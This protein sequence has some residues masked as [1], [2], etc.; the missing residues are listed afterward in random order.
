M[1]A[2]PPVPSPTPS[3]ALSISHAPTHPR[4]HSHTPLLAL[5]PKQGA[6]QEQQ[7]GGAGP[8]PLRHLP[9]AWNPSGQAASC[10]V[11]W[12]LASVPLPLFFSCC[13]PASHR[14]P[15]ALSAARRAWPPVSLQV[16]GALVVPL[17]AFGMPLLGL[18]RSKAKVGPACLPTCLRVFLFAELAPA[19]RGQGSR[20]WCVGQAIME[21]AYRRCCAHCP[22]APRIPL[23]LPP[24]PQPAGSS[25]SSGG[26][27]MSTKKKK[28]K[29]GNVCVCIPCQ[30]VCVECKPCGVSQR[31]ATFPLPMHSFLLPA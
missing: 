13:A 15:C 11:W 30:R 8:P 1:P 2:L 9:G 12:P 18:R 5:L 21:G 3:L 22:A 27:P 7:H 6:G 17:V 23:C 31:A 25:P 16:Y 29:V 20:L 4:A 28:S 24:V 14:L 10:R 26:A 19:A